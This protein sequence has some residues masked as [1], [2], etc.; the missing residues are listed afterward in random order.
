MSTLRRRQTSSSDK[1]TLNHHELIYTRS[2]DIKV[3]YSAYMGD[4]HGH[5]ETYVSTQSSIYQQP[6][7]GG[8]QSLTQ[9]VST[10]ARTGTQAIDNMRIIENPLWG[11]SDETSWNINNS[12]SYPEFEKIKPTY[13]TKTTRIPDIS[14]ASDNDDQ[15]SGPWSVWSSI[16]QAFCCFS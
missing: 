14:D 10:T 6:I 8:T 13:V 12:N 5:Y 3:E 11:L 9:T 2:A 4:I 7:A 1:R 16:R 15:E